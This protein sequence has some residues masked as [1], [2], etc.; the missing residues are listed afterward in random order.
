MKLLIAVG[1]FLALVSG[2]VAAGSLLDPA[3][4]SK[5]AE[6]LQLVT[7]EN[8]LAEMSTVLNIGCLLLAGILI[9]YTTLTGLLNSANEGR[10]MGKDYN[11]MWV[12]VRVAVAVALLLPM[13][14]YSVA[15][16]AV[17]K[18]AGYG[19]GFADSVWKAAILYM[20]NTGALYPPIA[21]RQGERLATALLNSA[22]CMHA[23]NRSYGQSVVRFVP[24]TSV[25]NSA[26][27][28]SIRFTGTGPGLPSVWAA[29]G[30]PTDELTVALTNPAAP[31]DICGVVNLELSRP[32]KTHVS[33]APKL[34]YMQAVQTALATLVDGTSDLAY[35]LTYR[36]ADYTATGDELHT[37]A[38]TYDAA[39]KTALA[40]A[41]ADLM[42]ARVDDTTWRTDALQFGFANAGAYYL[43]IARLNEETQD[44][45]LIEP[46]Y[47]EP[48]SEIQDFAD[49]E[50]NIARVRDYLGTR[51]TYNSYGEPVR[52]D[53]VAEDE[54]NFVA[55]MFKEARLGVQAALTANDN[56]V[57][58]MSQ[59]GR[60]LV[61]SVNTAAGVQ[62]TASG[63]S[64]F[65]R[66]IPIVGDAIADAAGT[67][68]DR[69]W[70]IFL[71][72]AAVMLIAA[73]V[74]GVYLPL[75]AWI[76]WILGML[77]W[78]VLCIEALIAAPIWAVAHAIPSGGNFVNSNSKQ[79]YMIL[80]SLAL[81]PTLM[82]FGLFAGMLVTIV[83]FK[84]MLVGSHAAWNSI[85]AGGIWGPAAWLGFALIL[86]GLTV[87][88][89][90]R[91]FGLIHEIPD[92]ILRYIGGG[93]E[94]LGEAGGEA[95]IRGF[96]VTGGRGM[97]GAAAAAGAK[98][99]GKPNGGLPGSGS[100]SAAK[101]AGPTA[102]NAE[103]D[104][105]PS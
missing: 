47:V 83:V 13:P 52:A 12:P 59:I 94:Q 84:I 85:S 48:R 10:V 9:A 24:E 5:A 61:T 18:I 32:D 56:P 66:V 55:R 22:G 58:T 75:A 4:G 74:F 2:P 98:G 102:K 99:A 7:Y 27:R 21:Q 6:Y 70:S 8:I 81:R 78:I 68:A 105:T 79:G 96:I 15:Q 95:A 33:Y 101:D 60:V 46:R 16:Q 11:S 63:L 92:K 20:D 38:S 86:A 103:R 49:Y 42:Q 26:Y 25:G 45:A 43:D 67:I 19:I 57:V 17:L 89:A 62:L 23:I 50:A 36:G 44:F 97:G 69:L 104:L 77:G 72:I 30:L 3:A 39:L 73:L 64:K 53:Q 35:R 87:M 1:L 54:S 41:T 71:P 28:L 90:H 31:V 93:I 34:E 91:G 29:E 76:F 40:S 37:L 14:N 82:V 80:L 100:V 88:I 51:I 65:A